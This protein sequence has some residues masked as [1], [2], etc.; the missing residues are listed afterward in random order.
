M[1]VKPNMSWTK[2][3]VVVVVVDIRLSLIVI[4]E[5]SI[6]CSGHLPMML[7]CD[8]SVALVVP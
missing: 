6:D 1:G 3:V 4:G 8:Y 2:H 5:W 7:W